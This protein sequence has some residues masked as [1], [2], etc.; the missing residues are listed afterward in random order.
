MNS[1]IQQLNSGPSGMQRSIYQTEVLSALLK[2]QTET[3]FP[4]TF[5]GTRL[6]IASQLITSR[7]A[8]GVDHDVLVIPF[9]GF[10]THSEL[11]KI[12][13]CRTQR[14][15]GNFRCRVK[16]NRNSVGEYRRYTSIRLLSYHDR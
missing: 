7:A 12:S 15:F 9:D 2:N 3:I 8:R 16:I 1:I 11:A 4:S 10:D 6:K 5:L 13:R 14:R